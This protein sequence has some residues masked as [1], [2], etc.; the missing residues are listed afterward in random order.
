MNLPGKYQKGLILIPTPIEESLPLEPVALQVLHEAATDP[1]ALILVEEHKVGRKRWLQ[2]GLP[3]SSIESFIVYNEHTAREAAP[4]V[5]AQLKAGKRAL[6]MSDGGLPAFCDPGRDLVNLC[7]EAR[8][9][10]TTTPFPNS[11]ALAVALS[12]FEHREFHFA[13]FLPAEANERKKSLELL[14]SRHPCTLVLMDT[15]YRLQTLL[16]DLSESPLKGRDLFLATSLN[17][18]QEALFR[19]KPKAVLERIGPLNKVEFVIVIG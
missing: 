17:S 8:I 9:A 3:R 7:H 10:V 1:D 18:D 13:G 2:W 16:K 12:G 15:P 6:L 19:G 11:I 4:G 14:A 5:L